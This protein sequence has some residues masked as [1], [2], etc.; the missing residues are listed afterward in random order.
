MNK[1][2]VITAGM[3]GLGTG[4][5][6]GEV[7]QRLEINS[8]KQDVEDGAICIAGE[9]PVRQEEDGLLH[10]LDI[11]LEVADEVS[12]GS[13]VSIDWQATEERLHGSLQFAQDKERRAGLDG[14]FGVMGAAL[15][16]GV[17]YIVTEG[18]MRS[19]FYAPKK[20]SSSRRLA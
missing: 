17:V 9:V 10:C 3:L 13:T 20:F 12:E 15:V 18:H 19:R 1:P 14:I 7:A 6:V 5:S 16:G 11:T 8:A 4:V 2:A